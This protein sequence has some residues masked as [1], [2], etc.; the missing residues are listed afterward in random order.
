MTVYKYP[1]PKQINSVYEGM[2]WVI[3]NPN[4]KSC[5]DEAIILSETPSINE[6]CRLSSK[7]VK[8]KRKIK[9]NLKSMRMLTQP[10]LLLNLPAVK[11]RL[12][13]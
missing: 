9:K 13:N 2:T 8:C 4:F 7:L 5:F 11:I 1:G 10:G 12:K 3:L 6:I